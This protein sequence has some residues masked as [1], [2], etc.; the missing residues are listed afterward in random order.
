MKRLTRRSIIAASLAVV[1]ALS[2]AACGGSS[3]SSSSDSGSSS[4]G[5]SASTDGD[6]KTFNMVLSHGL[7]EDHPVHIQLLDYADKV[8]EASNGT[9]NI[10]IRANAVL[11]SEADNVAS[12]QAGA[13]EMAKVSASTL[14][15]YNST[16]DCVSV[17]YVFDDK[18]HYYRVMDGDIAEDLYM[19]TEDDG[20]I[21]LTWF[22][23]GSRSFYTAD[24]AIREPEDLKG[25]KIRTMD[26]TMA[27]EM[28]DAFGGSATVLGYSDIYTA[29]QNGTIDGAENNITAMHDHAEVT[30]YY[31]YDEHTRIPDIL[32]ISLSTWNQL[33]PNQQE[34]MKSLAREAT[35]EYK[36]AWAEAE[37][38]YR[39]FAEDVGVTFIEDVD[40]PAF[41]AA[42]QSIYDGLTGEVAEYVARIRA[43][44]D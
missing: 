9:I 34:I 44:A 32:V 1:M 19:I 43:E 38:E 30:K 39:A 7:A 17:P 33:S 5:A 6:E 14:S 16:W 8:K 42:C 23:S 37:Q 22:D 3:G 11:G 25:L 27:I 41:Q 4:G 13:L 18:D 31:C 21:A 29:M 2:L 24:K 15:N 36:T 12:L 10:T 26:S 20:F 28:M 40:K 35:E